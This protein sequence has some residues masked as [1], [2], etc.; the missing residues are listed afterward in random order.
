M[1]VDFKALTRWLE[2]DEGCRLKP[3]YCTAN[4][5][6][7]GIGRNLEDRGITKAE[8]HFMLENDI[9]QTMRELDEQFP[10]WK[11]L[12]DIRKMVI[13]NMAFNLGTFGL[14][15]FKRTIAHL[16]AQ[17]WDKAA[18][19]MLRSHWADQ[20]GNR[21]KRLSEAMRTDELPI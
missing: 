15:N 4:K 10:E 8:A 18:E 3:Y 17:E 12:S 14:L 13:V 5:L 11:E 2:L 21:A 20:V 6:T 19:E 16:R 7:I 1:S 9:V